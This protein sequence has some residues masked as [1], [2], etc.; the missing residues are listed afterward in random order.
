MD[1]ERRQKLQEQKLKEEKEYFAARSVHR[2]RAQAQA[3]PARIS[4]R[5]HEEAQLKRHRL[6]ERM[7]EKDGG[8]SDVTNG[9]AYYWSCAHY[10]EGGK[11]YAT[12]GC[13]CACLTPKQ[14]ELLEQMMDVGS[15]LIFIDGW[16]KRTGFI[17]RLLPQHLDCGCYYRYCYLPDAPPLEQ[18]TCRAADK[19]EW[20]GLSEVL[21]EAEDSDRTMELDPTTEAFAANGAKHPMMTM[22]E[23]DLCDPSMI[24]ESGWVIVKGAVSERTAAQGDWRVLPHLSSKERPSL[25]GAIESLQEEHGMT[26]ESLSKGRLMLHELA[27]ELKLPGTLRWLREICADLVVCCPIVNLE[28]PLA[29]K[30]V[31]VPCVPLLTT[32]GPGSAKLFWENILRAL[33][34]TAEELLEERSQ[35]QGLGI[36]SPL[37]VRQMLRQIHGNHIIKIKPSFLPHQPWRTL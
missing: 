37:C 23:D 24:E 1:A 26:N 25:Y 28:A 2:A 18:V 29:A 19:L 34:L 11:Y 8:Y 4:Q 12:K 33:G 9:Q 22:L 7:R 31:Q 35:F 5:L 36:R 32:A 27:V 17:R 13:I 30:V 14:E 15:S 16:V 21:E 10:C 6:S 3:N 20:P